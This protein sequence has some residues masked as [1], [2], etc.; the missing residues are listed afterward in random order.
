MR[1]GSIDAI[2]GALSVAKVARDA[3]YGLVHD[4]A[5]AARNAH[6]AVT[7][8]GTAA[9]V[10]PVQR[11][12]TENLR[13]THGLALRAAPNVEF[14]RGADR[15]REPAAVIECR[16]PK[17]VHTFAAMAV[18]LAQRLAHT[19]VTSLD[20]VTSLFSE[21]ERLLGRR[22]LLAGESELGLW[23]ELWCLARTSR[24]NELLDAWRGPEREHLD[25]L[26]DGLGVEVKASRT[27]GV[28]FVSQTQLDSSVGQIDLVLLSLHVLPDPIRGRTLPE[29]VR[30]IAADVDDVV[31]FEAKLASVGYS[32]ADEA[33]YSRRFA[34]VEVP[35]VFAAEDVPRVR[36]ADPGVSD[37]RYRVELRPESA[38]R[39]AVLDRVLDTL[40]LD[41]ADMRLPCV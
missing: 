10:V 3:E 30:Q 2:V 21:W 14:V 8:D 26:L 16:D 41:I 25:L 24:K 35:L 7:K 38:L 20:T 5:W 15:W 36:L 34:L 32:R 31:S 37:L 1:L 13:L 22:Q 9:L 17:L 28:H 4:P 33:A 18:A 23:G 12:V 40:A 29:L 6:L 39:G 19:T 27:S 11:V